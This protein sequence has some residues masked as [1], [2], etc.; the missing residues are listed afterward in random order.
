VFEPIDALCLRR[1]IY[2][3]SIMAS[4]LS[5][6]PE[7]LVIVFHHLGKPDLKRFRCA[8]HACADLV[9]QL[10]FVEV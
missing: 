5:V 4:L 2:Q 6:P 9:T 1:I 8:S 7:L 10:L 3:G